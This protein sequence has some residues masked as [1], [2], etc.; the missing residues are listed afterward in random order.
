MININDD[1]VEIKNNDLVLIEMFYLADEFIW[2]LKSCDIVISNDDEFYFELEKIMNNNYTFDNKYMFKNNEL[3]I[4]L[5]DQYC[6]IDNEEEVNKINRLIIKKEEDRFVISVSNP[7]MES[8]NINGKNHVICFS[9][10]GNGYYS[11]NLES[12]L[13]LQDDFCLMYQNLTNI[14][15]HV[16]K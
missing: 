12:G 5:S 14:K 8:L 9:P 1:I 13:S 7:Y 15:K 16:L 3:L 2:I 10:M 11:R 4:W 6:D